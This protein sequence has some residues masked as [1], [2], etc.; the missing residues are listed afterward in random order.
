MLEP[1]ERLI[2]HVQPAAARVAGDFAPFNADEWR[3]IPQPSQFARDLIGDELSVGEHLEIA[4]RVRRE[5]IQQ[6]RMQKWLTAENP[7][8]TIAMPLGVANQPVQFGER[9][10]LRRR[11]HIHPAPLA[12]ELASRD[13]GD[14]QKGREVF[15]AAQPALIEF[16]RA[17]ALDTEVVEEFSDDLRVGFGQHALGEREEHRI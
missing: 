4:I 6:L 7:E 3:Y 12:A 13:D 2:Q 17:D 8:I 15:S 5:K 10:A 11:F 16:H 1:A 14:K 9:K